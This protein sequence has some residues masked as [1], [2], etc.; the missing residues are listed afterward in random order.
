MHRALR[1]L[2]DAAL[3]SERIDL[4]HVAAYR[5]PAVH[6]VHTIAEV[7]PA[8]LV[9]PAPPRASWRIVLRRSI[10]ARLLRTVSQPIVVV[11]RPAIVPMTRATLAPARQ[12]RHAGDARFSRRHAPPESRTR[13]FN[14]SATVVPSVAGQAVCDS[15]ADVWEAGRQVKANKGA[16]GVD[17]QI[18]SSSKPI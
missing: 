7:R 13:S 9:V 5:L 11:P 12:N 14:A 3:E 6:L 1:E 15:Q 4:R 2:V 16:P 8:L 10:G 18:L 17:G